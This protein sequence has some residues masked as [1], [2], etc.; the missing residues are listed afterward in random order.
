MAGWTLAIV[1]L[2]ASTLA[3]WSGERRALVIGIDQYRELRPL[4]N[5]HN[6]AEAIA[7]ALRR[8]GWTVRLSLDPGRNVMWDAIENLAEALGPEDHGL[9]YFAGHGFDMGGENY[10]VP[11]DVRPEDEGR[12]QRRS[13]SV[14]E[15]LRELTWKTSA[16]VLVLVDACRNDPF[17][18]VAGDARGA[19]SL[20]A[21]IKAGYG[22]GEMKREDALLRLGDRHSGVTMLVSTSAG[23]TALDGNGRHSP[24]AETVLELLREPDLSLPSLVGFTR[25]RVYART[26]RSQEPV[27]YVSGRTMNLTLTGPASSMPRGAEKSSKP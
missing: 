16:G 8:N 6:D 3:A 27:Y 24:F 25:D 4:R 5:A 15:V 10:L 21:Q 2:V 14:W 13:L 12:L 20:P 19:I 22:F 26:R 7:Q 23:R 17:A 9:L 18:G 11:S 1:L